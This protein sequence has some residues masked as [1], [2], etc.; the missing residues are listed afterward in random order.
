VYSTRIFKHCS[1]LAS[2]EACEVHGRL[3]G[4]RGDGHRGAGE[5][6]HRQQPQGLPADMPGAQRHVADQRGVGANRPRRRRRRHARLRRRRPHHVRHGR[7]LYLSFPSVYLSL[8][9]IRTNTYS[10]CIFHSSFVDVIRL[11]CTGARNVRSRNC[12]FTKKLFCIMPS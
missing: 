9:G 7:P 11:M 2:R 3:C 12:R 4:D 5:G 6:D 10:A 1:R 8:L